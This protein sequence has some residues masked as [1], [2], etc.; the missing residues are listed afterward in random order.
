MTSAVVRTPPKASFRWLTLAVDNKAKGIFI[1]LGG[2]LDVTLTS[3]WLLAVE[4]CWSWQW[5]DIL[6]L[7]A[8]C[9]FDV[10]TLDWEASFLNVLRQACYN[11]NGN[12]REIASP[13]VEIKSFRDKVLFIDY[14]SCF[15]HFGSVWFGEPLHYVV[16]NGQYGKRCLTVNILQ[17]ALLLKFS[18]PI[19]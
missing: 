5:V 6:Y 8:A 16:W 1:Q 3:C 9:I 15:Q 4:T 12:L 19:L 10:R 14:F 7:Q 18:N 2:A 17:V 13:F 11:L